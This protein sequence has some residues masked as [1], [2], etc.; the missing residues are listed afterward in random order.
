M[1]CWERTANQKHTHRKIVLRLL[2]QWFFL[3]VANKSVFSP[4]TSAWQTAKSPA[5]L[6]MARLSFPPVPSTYSSVFPFHCSQHREP[7]NLLGLLS[8]LLPQLE[9]LP[10]LAQPQFPHRL[11]PSE[12]SDL[13]PQLFKSHLKSFPPPGFILLSP[14]NAKC[15]GTLCIKCVIG[16]NGAHESIVL[17]LRDFG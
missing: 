1:I 5:R 6:L 2:E 15:F 7:P 16:T 10:W 13:S 4:S 12:L 8:P 17:N 3:H 11:P 14:L 9:V